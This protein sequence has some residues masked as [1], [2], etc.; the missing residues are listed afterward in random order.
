MKYRVIMTLIVIAVAVMLYL[1]T[2]GSD[3]ETPQATPATDGIK[4]Q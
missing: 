3:T 4:L 1:F 2:D